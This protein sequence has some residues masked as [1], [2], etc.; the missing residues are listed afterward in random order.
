MTGLARISLANRA[1]VIMIA[2]VLSGV[3]VYAI[4]Q[5]KQQLFPSL[6]LPMVS[7]VTPYAGA[8]PEIVEDQVTEPIENQLRSLDGVE[9]LS[10]TS[11]E[12]VST[13]RV[14]FDYGGET[15]EQVSDIESAVNE[16]RPDL[17]EDLD[18]QVIAGSTDDIPVLVLAVSNGGSQ[19]DLADRLERAVVPELE[20]IPD[21]RDAAITGARDDQVVVTPDEDELAE[22]GLTP[23]SVTEALKANGVVVPAGSLTAGKRTLTVQVGAK[24]S[25]VKDI[26]SIYVTQ[27]PQQPA[28]PPQLALP[29]PVQLSEVATVELKAEKATSLTRTKG[30]PSLGV[31][32]TM[33]EDGNAVGISNQVRDKINDLAGSLGSGAK[34]TVVFD[35]SPYVERSIEDLTT[36]GVLGLVFAVIVIMVF[37]VSLRSTLVTAVSIPLSVVIALIALWLGDYSLNMLTLGALTISI[38]RVVDDSIVVLENIRRHLAYGEPKRQAVLDGVREVAGAVTSSTLTTVAVFLPIA[39]VSGLVGQLFSSFAVT[40]TVALLASLLVSLTVIP[41][42]AYWFM[43]R[44][45]HAD[46]EQE[47]VRARAEAAELRNPLQRAY[48][49]ILH[50]A[51][52][53]RLLTILVGAAV[54]VGTFALIPGMKTN[55]LDSS[56]QDTTQVNLA[57]PEGSDLKTTDAA[58]KRIERVLADTDSVESYQVNIGSGNP[59]FGGIGGATNQAAYSVTVKE[60]ADTP[61][62]EAELRTEVAELSLDG[63]VTVGRRGGNQEMGGNAVEVIVTGADRQALAKA[64]GQVEGAV[65]GID[66]VR[67]VTSDLSDAAPRVEVDVDQ[68]EAAERGLTEAVIGQQVAQAFRGSPVG[69]VSISGRNLELVLSSGKAPDDLAAIKEL[70]LLTATGPVELADVAAVKQVKG[71]TQISRVDG[72]RAA[73]VTAAA[74]TADLSAITQELTDGLQRLDLPGGTDYQIGG[75]SADQQKAFA[76]LQLAMLIAIALV[77]MVMVATFRSFVQP[78]ILLVSIPFAATGA[79]GLLR[80]TDTPL[81]VPAMIGLLMLIGIVVT[82]AIVLIDLINQYR[83]QGMEIRDAVIAGGRRRLRPILMTAVATISALIPMAIGL[84]GSGGFIAQSLAVVVIGGLVSSTLLTLVLVPTLYSLVESAKQWFRR[85]FRRTPTRPAAE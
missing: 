30:K 18:P 7:V 3:G 42:L 47:E 71:P 9:E 84:T 67:D 38:G 17:P 34:I 55:F 65:K 29:E 22:R 44:P 37:L 62:V 66:G 48:V 64:A 68:Q 10:S 59:M 36:E 74:D 39:F 58:A 4:P 77:F 43:S 61:A 82:N 13:V 80:V 63:D 46:D 16:V 8:A 45:K 54:L 85:R 73:T 41:V 24:L 78:L 51:T 81:G 60:G 21:V 32:V 50:F 40:V 56:G 1:L 2:L 75:S 72:E 52:R 31:S 28:A 25:G 69:E 83:R 70:E 12:G 27:A 57:M 20:A 6:S 23:A 19:R 35:Q 14:A 26:E 76:D 5:L 53:F 49:P 11:G 33:V 79:I 15:G